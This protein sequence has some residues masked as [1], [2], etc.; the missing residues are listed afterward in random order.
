MPT[1]TVPGKPI[2][3]PRHRHTRTGRLYIPKDHPVHKYIADVRGAWWAHWGP[4][5]G[6]V[7]VSMQ[8][9]FPRPK[10][11]KH[12]P[13]GICEYKSK[14]DSDNVFKAATDALTGYAWWDDCTVDIGGV[15]RFYHERGG[16]PKTIITIEPGGSL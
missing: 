12:L 16:E 15:R 11:D 2:G 7:I 14:P 3:K 1:F 9:Y 6:K 10:R 5:T 8:C 13:E 4:L